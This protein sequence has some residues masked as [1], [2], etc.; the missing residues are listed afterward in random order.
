MVNGN[1]QSPITIYSPNP[2]FDYGYA[3]AHLCWRTA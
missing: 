3:S 1:Y 2:P